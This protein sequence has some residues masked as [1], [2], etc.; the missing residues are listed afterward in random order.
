V[1]LRLPANC[2]LQ[3]SPRSF[4]RSFELNIENSL[5]ITHLFVEFTRLFKCAVGLEGSLALRVFELHREVVPYLVNKNNG[6]LVEPL[7]ALAILPQTIL[8]LALGII[9]VGAEAVLLSLVPPALVFAAIGPVVDTKALLLVHEVLPVVAY[10]IGINVDA[11]TLH[12]I[13][14][15]LTVVLSTVF[16]QVDAVSIDFV[17]QPLAFVSGSICPCI[18]SSSLFLTHDVLSLVFCAFRPSF[19]TLSMLL[20]FF[21]VAFVPCTFNIS[22]DSEAVRL[23][24]HP[25]AI[26]DVA[27]SME[28]LSLPARLIVLPVTLIASCIN[29]HHVTSS[30]AQTTLPLSRVRSTSAIS[31]N[32]ILK[33]SIILVGSSKC[34][35]CFIALEV[36][37]L[38]LTSQ[39]H[40]TILATLEEATYEG[41]NSH[42]SRHVLLRDLNAS[43]SS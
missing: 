12:V 40:D 36:L 17:V 21:P 29:P 38:Y 6:L 41:L 27:I 26:I 24:V 28:E 14:L 25:A 18:F 3:Q 7:H 13:R 34:L 11:V 10:S 33:S 9:Y 4:T 23:I 30:M 35:F 22:I 31:V 19:N 43:I 1:S 20:I 5:D 8:N 16:P 2:L 42:N 39:L 15:P 32:S 37:A